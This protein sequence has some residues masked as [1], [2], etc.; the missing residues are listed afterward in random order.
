MDVGNLLDYLRGI[1]IVI[2]FSDIPQD[3]PL[4]RVDI[5]HR[6]RVTWLGAVV[7]G[8]CHYCHVLGLDSADIGASGLWRRSVLHRNC[9]FDDERTMVG[10]G[11]HGDRSSR[12]NSDWVIPHLA[13]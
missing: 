11:K 6:E 4:G 5:V 3:T 7:M 10:C 9:R 12:W 1:P 13:G 8:M 2:A